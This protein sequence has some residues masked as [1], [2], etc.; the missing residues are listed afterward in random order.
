[1]LTYVVYWIRPWTL[2]LW[3][4]KYGEDTVSEE[5]QCV[6]TC[7]RALVEEDLL[8]RCWYGLRG[9]YCSVIV[10]NGCLNIWFRGLSLIS[11][12]SMSWQ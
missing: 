11:T 3:Q 5:P 9:P 6:S 2:V 1:M 8:W 10:P 7:G 12:S 4:L